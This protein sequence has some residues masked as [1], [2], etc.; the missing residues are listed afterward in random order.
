[1]SKCPYCQPLEQ[2]KTMK[3][4]KA[5]TTAFDRGFFDKVKKKLGYCCRCELTARE[6]ELV[7]IQT[8]PSG[9]TY[10]IRCPECKFQT[11]PNSDIVVACANWNDLMKVKPL[12]VVKDH[13]P[14]N[15]PRHYTK[16]PEGI[17]C[18]QV[19]RHMNFNRGNAVKYIWRA[20]EKGDTIEDLRKAIWYL[21][22]EIKRLEM[23]KQKSPELA[24]GAVK[25][26]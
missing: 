12:E 20:G 13:D 19:T 10:S 3:E 4:T 7:T 11:A 16:H 9:T 6:P 2:Q 14:V 5:D 25:P 18:I 21:S 22:D 1:M 24:S 8:I 23:E 17:E 26:T 15:H